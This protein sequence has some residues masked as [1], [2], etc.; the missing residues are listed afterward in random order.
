MQN[1]INRVEELYFTN[2][3]SKTENKQR[4]YAFVY[5]QNDGKKTAVLIRPDRNGKLIFW[6]SIHIVNEKQKKWKKINLARLKQG[7]YKS[8]EDAI[9]SIHQTLNASSSR[10]FSAFTDSIIITDT[11]E[12]SNQEVFRKRKV[13]HPETLNKL[14]GD[15]YG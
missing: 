9:P 10:R 6:K 14:K 11:V 2:D 8:V 12:K 7:L 3:E 1:I 4:T 15:K 13:I 5:K